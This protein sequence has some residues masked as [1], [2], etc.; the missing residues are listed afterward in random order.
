MQTAQPR[1]QMR[2]RPDQ[3]VLGVR[4]QIGAGQ[5]MPRFRHLFRGQGH[6]RPMALTGRVAVMLGFRRIEDQMIR[7]QSHGAMMDR[8][9]LFVGKEENAGSS[10]Q[11]GSVL[12]PRERLVTAL[13]PQL[14]QVHARQ[15]RTERPAA[16]NDDFYLAATD[17][18]L[19]FVWIDEAADQAARHCSFPPRRLGSTG[20]PHAA[21]NSRPREAVHSVQ[22]NCHVIRRVR[23]K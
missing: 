19:V 7:S 3:A 16:G 1:H 18:L 15:R 11:K 6:R 9:L 17:E 13:E 5:R 4:H 8:P 21:S 2:W 14:V 20:C 10:F 22:R 23:A 12:D